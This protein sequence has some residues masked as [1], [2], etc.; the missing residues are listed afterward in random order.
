MNQYEDLIT[1]YLDW[2]RALYKG[3]V[4]VRK[5]AETNDIFVETNVYRVKKID[6]CYEKSYNPQEVL[7]VIVNSNTRIVHVIYNKWVKFW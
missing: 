5:N 6:G 2:T 4:N 1:P 3:L 7:Y